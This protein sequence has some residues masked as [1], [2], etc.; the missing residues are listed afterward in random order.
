MGLAVALGGAI[1]YQKNDNPHFHGNLHLAT[2]CQFKTLYE[3][4]DLLRQKL[5]NVKAI[6]D[7]Q[8]WICR[9]E[10]FDQAKHNRE[11]RS[12]E[13]SW[14]ENNESPEHD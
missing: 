3:V 8:S 1:E 6:T 9:E 12:L 5:V 11:C 10:H 2:M 4:A 14:K 13:R 7:F